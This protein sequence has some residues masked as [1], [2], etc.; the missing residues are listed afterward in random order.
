MSLWPRG[1]RAAG[2]EGGGVAGDDEGGVYKGLWCGG[3]DAEDIS[4]EEEEE[5]IE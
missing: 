5:E 1:V 2:D 4:K 3:G